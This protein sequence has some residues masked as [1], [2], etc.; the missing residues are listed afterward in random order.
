MP[1]RHWAVDSARD[2]LG[3]QRR[4]VVLLYQ[5][6]RTRTKTRPMVG[7]CKQPREPRPIS[8]A[9]SSTSEVQQAPPRI[10]TRIAN[11]SVARRGRCRR[12]SGGEH[13]PQMLPHGNKGVARWSTNKRCKET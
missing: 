2:K 1:P 4:Q 3:K 13:E 9:T 7:A 8:F 11:T 6:C 5:D 10:G 12:H